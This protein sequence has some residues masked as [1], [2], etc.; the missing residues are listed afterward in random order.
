MCMIIRSCIMSVDECNRTK[1]DLKMLKIVEKLI[2]EKKLN[3]IYS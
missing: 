3:R 2:L 1:I